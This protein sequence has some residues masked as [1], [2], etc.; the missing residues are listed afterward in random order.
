MSRRNFL[1]MAFLSFEQ[2]IKKIDQLEEANIIIAALEFR[3]FTHLEKKSLSCQTLANKAGLH[4]EGAEALFNALASLGVIRK[5]GNSFA[6]TPDGY[7]HFCENSPHFKKGTIFLRKE[8]RDEWSKL[9]NTIKQ[10]RNIS[11]LSNEDP[12]FREPFTYAMHERSSEFSKPLSKIVTRKPVGK[13]IDLGG[14]PGSYSAEILK[15]DKL[16][17][18][19][20]IDRQASLIVA[21]EILKKSKVMKRI[22]FVAG[23]LFEVPFGNN[24]DTAL[25]S[26]ILHIYNKAQNTKILKKINK[27]LK[28]GGRL[29]L[30]DYFLKNNLIEPF[31]AALFS[32]TMLLFTATGK[33]YTF[34]ETKSLL[35][36]NGFGKFKRYELNQGCSALEAIK[37]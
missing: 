27:S 15:I 33:T 35:K 8:N 18:A 17:Q 23:D 24:V 10:G 29:I 5:V 16:A 14:G 3:V 30:V 32:L 31:R 26:N 25:Y 13:L 6:N 37:I 4:F 34:E 12:G 11:D 22:S 20:L 2:I 36:K 1:F 19:V 7:K 9:T 21:K 28:P